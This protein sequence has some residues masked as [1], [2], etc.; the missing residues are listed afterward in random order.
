[1][2]EIHKI[3][4]VG[5]DKI[6]L[7]GLFILSLLVAYIIT[8]SKSALLLS[9]P[10]ELGY[11]GLSMS[12]PSGNGWHSQEQWRYYQDVFIL[13][14]VFTSESGVATAVAQCRFLFAVAGVSAQ[15]EFERKAA[16]VGGTIAKK[17]Q[18]RKESIVIDWAQITKPGT[19]LN[20]FFALS[21]LPYNRRLIFEVQQA[22]GDSNLAEKAFNR[23]V[24]SIN[25]K[26]NGLLKAGSEVVEGLRDKGIAGFLDNRNQQ[27]FFLIKTVR[28]R[29]EQTVGFTMEVLVEEGEEA[30]PKIDA[31]GLF[32][33]RIPYSQ[34]QVI[35]FKSDNSFNEFVW[36]SESYGPTGRSGA[37]IILEKNAPMTVRR[38]DV[39]PEEKTYHL[40]AAAVPSVFLQQLLSE[41]LNGDK[42]E[43]VV[44]VIRSDGK[45]TPA[46]ISR[47]EAKDAA[48]NE[49]VYTLEV[50]LSS[51]GGFSERIYLDSQR[52]ISRKELRLDTVSVFERATLKN[53][54]DEFP[55]RADAILRSDKMPKTDILQ[56]IDY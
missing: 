44:D 5:G 2:N 48:D 12:M 22:K 28:M 4:R 20:L 17:G 27:V 41:M 6:A 43:I 47:T 52:Q 16:E 24:E 15:A 31:A 53:I 29:T 42:K 21:E 23:I 30:E 14:S 37:E 49:A 39:E 51:E 54:L 46:Y 18:T 34:E 1:M 10:I 45:I 40:S 50:G 13:G 32:Y 55:E 38:F 7:L 25:F 36:K 19:P 56:E 26:D 8:I 35:S 33:T 9:G 11:T 3:K